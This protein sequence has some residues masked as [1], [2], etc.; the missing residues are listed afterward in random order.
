MAVTSLSSHKE[1]LMKIGNE[2]RSYVLLYKE[3]SEQSECAKKNIEAVAEKN[4]EANIFVA[5]V[6]NVR[7]IHRIYNITT[8]PALI[9]FEVGKYRNTFKGCHNEDFYQTLLDKIIF[10]AKASERSRKKVTIYTTKT[11]PW[12][13]TV[14][15]YLRKNGVRYTEVDI[16]SDENAAR[17]MVA[18]SGQQ[19]VPQT[20]IDGQMVIGFDQNKLNKLLE[21]KIN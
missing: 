12:C 7:D 2:K 8:V 10:E 6:K 20:E 19:G 1:L 13:T 16:A 15:N 18:K 14:K 11:C 5:N 17:N 4:N 3:G 9:E 21:I